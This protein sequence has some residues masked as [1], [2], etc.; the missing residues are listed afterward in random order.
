MR[1]LLLFVGH[2]ILAKEPQKGFI[3]GYQFRSYSL[4]HEVA[5][6]IKSQL[7]YQDAVLVTPKNAN[8]SSVYKGLVILGAGPIAQYP[9]LK[10][11][12]KPYLKSGLPVIT[13]KNSLMS[14]AFCTPAQHKMSRVFNVVSTNLTEPC[15]VVVK[16]Y[17]SGSASYLPAA[18]EEFSKPGCKLKLAGTIFD[19]GPPMMTPIESIYCSKF[20]AMQN[21][22]PTWF[23]QL[24]ELSTPLL[25]SILNGWRKRASMER[26]MYSPFLHHTPQLYVYSTSDDIINVD[27]INKL[28]DYQRQH[29]ADV[30]RHTFSD[31]LH[32][33][34]HLKYP[35]EYDNLLFDFLRNKC[36]LPI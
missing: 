23:H 12:S 10:Q 26:L 4:P 19:S 21:R 33:L 24:Q 30:T 2:R 25:L 27:Y 28:I 1:R 9:A 22:Y 32:M 11:F 3:I 36:K 16:V 15:P 31:T 35:K 5:E 7:K 8:P 13:M 18:A 14:W 20:F 29:N 17:C 34:H 6:K